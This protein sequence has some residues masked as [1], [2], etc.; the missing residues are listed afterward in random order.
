MLNYRAELS[1]QR[2]EP[3][4]L[5]GS[6][7]QAA[8][9]DLVFQKT[10][11][12]NLQGKT[13]TDEAMTVVMHIETS[14]PD[15]A[16]GTVD[17][18]QDQNSTRK[19]SRLRRR[20]QVEASTAA[21]EHEMKTAAELSL[22]QAD[23]ETLHDVDKE[24]EPKPVRRSLRIRGQQK[25]QMR[26]TK[27][28]VNQT[29][30]V[31][32]SSQ[33]ICLNSEDVTVAENNRSSEPNVAAG[34]CDRKLDANSAGKNSR[35]SRRKQTKANAAAS[36]LEVETNAEP[37]LLQVDTEPLHD[38]ASELEPKPLRRSLRTCRQQKKQ[39]IQPEKPV[40]QTPE[41]NC[42]SA[43]HIALSKNCNFVDLEGEIAVNSAKGRVPSPAGNHPI[44]TAEHE[45][46]DKKLVE[47]AA[48]AAEIDDACYS[49]EHEDDNELETNL[50]H[51]SLLNTPEFVI[52]QKS[53]WSFS[54]D[55]ENDTD[56]DTVLLLDVDFSEDDENV[57]R[58]DDDDD[59]F[60]QSKLKNLTDECHDVAADEL[61]G[62]EV[63]SALV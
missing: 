29:S 40:N 34:I 63:Q 7:N 23:T 55:D 48:A 24:V 36:E 28:S 3:D 39:V 37:Q 42:D 62:G 18:E 47:V 14:Q 31:D 30:K 11:V 10:L 61:P 41:V 1:P 43:V 51:I 16:A 56:T 44:E 53:W 32:C 12:H 49:C 20:K 35:L 57:L 17:R 22:Q 50:A 25:Q 6:G 9:N 19:S 21:S 2:D 38:V 54:E 5:S 27:K 46:S 58:P 15:V 4:A 52:G 45:S 60:S 13:K 59:L 33:D 26:Q 8:G